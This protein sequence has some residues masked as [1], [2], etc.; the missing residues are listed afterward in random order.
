MGNGKWRIGNKEKGIAK[1]KIGAGAA[2]WSV[3]GAASRV[4]IGIGK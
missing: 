2:A 1:R 3:R 4:R